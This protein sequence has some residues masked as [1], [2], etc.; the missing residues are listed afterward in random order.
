MEIKKSLYWVLF[1][2]SI[3]E[4]EPMKRRE[5]ICD[6]HPFI[7]RAEWERRYREQN[8]R[9]EILDWKELGEKEGEMCLALT[10][11]RSPE[12]PYKAAK[13]HEES[14]DAEL[15]KPENANRYSRTEK[16]KEKLN[17]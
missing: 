11:A 14:V 16:E 1:E 13:W 3:A 7:Y 4:G 9:I 10:S 8:H 6:M 17:K 2:H 15:D 5:T 12:N